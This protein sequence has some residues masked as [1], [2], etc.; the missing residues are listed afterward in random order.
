LDVLALNTLREE[1][2]TFHR[3]AALPGVE[4]LHATFV[5]HRYPAHVHDYWVVARVDRGA[6]AFEL[7]GRQHRAAAG[8]M[9]V[10]PPGAVHTGE[11]A[12]DGGYTY[13]V[14]YVDWATLTCGAEPPHEARSCLASPVS[15]NRSCLRAL[16]RLHEGLVLP[17]RS[18]EQGEAVATVSR[19]LREIAAPTASRRRPRGHPAAARAKAYINTH[20]QDNFT[21]HDLAEAA[22][23]SPFHL[24]RVFHR[25]FGMAPSTY[26]RALRVQ[27]A[28]NLLRRGEPARDVAPACGFY[29]QSHLTRHFKAVTGVT[30]ARYA[31]AA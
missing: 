2:A 30:P 21:L 7:E 12:S 8:S 6:A 25:A 4:A 18:L 5:E 24:V 9:F 3:P 17:G 28:Q 20:W 15:D 11:S 27:A 13:R 10:I 14:L 29:D 23:V 19:A 26:R 22:D 16:D 31:R 1:H